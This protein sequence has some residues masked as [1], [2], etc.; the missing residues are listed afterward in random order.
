MARRDRRR[1]IPALAASLLVHLALLIVVMHVA[2]VTPRA[3]EP[4]AEA[5]FQVQLVTRPPPPTSTTN[6]VPQLRRRSVQAA[7]LIATRRAPARPRPVPAPPPQA[8]QAVRPAPPRTYRPSTAPPARSPAPSSPVGVSPGAAAR[9]GAPSEGRWAVQGEDEGQDGV[10]K[11]LRA[12]V[13]CSHEDYVA[14]NGQERAASD[15][16]IGAEARSIGIP[17]DKIAGFIAAAE[18]QERRRADR[19]GPMKDLFV[20]CTGP[21]S[22]LDRGCINMTSK[23]PEDEPY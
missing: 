6:A 4:V 14:L 20:P 17:S 22:N 12:T 10:R 1:A 23:H 5:D 21:G 15:R 13:G 18:A 11:F 3:S 19:T 8:V 16:R 7:P 2:G 9:T